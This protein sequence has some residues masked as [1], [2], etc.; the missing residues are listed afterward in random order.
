MAGAAGGAAVAP[1]S[2]WQ[3]Q[4]TLTLLCRR[5]V[6]LIARG[7]PSVTSARVYVP[8][9]VQEQIKEQCSQLSPPHPT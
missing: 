6:A 4:H 8:H 3:S 2:F 5:E 9:T 1:I 7:E